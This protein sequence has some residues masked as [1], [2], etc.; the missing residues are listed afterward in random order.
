MQRSEIMSEYV[1]RTGCAGKDR[2]IVCH[3]TCTLQNSTT[4]RR[5]E[6]KRK[7]QVNAR[8][9]YFLATRKWLHAILAAKLLYF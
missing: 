8:N 7:P 2:H 5:T 6:H 3:V 1:E 9:I 4:N